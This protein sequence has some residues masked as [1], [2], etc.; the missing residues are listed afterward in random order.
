MKE[1]YTWRKEHFNRVSEY[2]WR[3]KSKEVEAE[4][5]AEFSKYAL[6]IKLE[7]A[8]SGIPEPLHSVYPFG[9]DKDHYER[10]DSFIQTNRV[11]LPKGKS[12]V[13]TNEGSY[14][15]ILRQLT[16]GLAYDSESLAYELSTSRAD[17][18]ESVID[19]VQGPVLVSVFYKAE[20]VALRRR[21]GARARAFVG[22][23]PITERSRL[24]HAWNADEIPILLAAPAA[25]GHGIN[26]QYG[27]ARTIVWHS[28]SFDWAQ[29]SQFNARLVRS[30]QTKTVSI[31]DL[32]GDIGIDR[33]VLTALANKQAGESAIMEAL[34]IRHRFTPSEV[35]YG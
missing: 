33:A 12:R 15:A 8:V 22:D 27:S 31:I 18:L 4:I 20:V 5:R 32:V 1:F 34:D 21:F 3:V 28:H 19:D 16:S 6:A 23:T 2:S 17:A 29:R 11:A 10:I 7:D 9:W 25:M 26:L 30:G 24:I 35:A 13:A 14:L